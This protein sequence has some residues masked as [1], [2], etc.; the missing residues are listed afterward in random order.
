MDPTRESTY[1]F[2]NRFVG[3]MSKI[4]PD[5]YFHIGGDEVEG[6]I[7]TSNP[8]IA[9]FMKHKGFET[10]PQLQTYFNQR[11][12][13][14]VEKHRKKPIGWDEV[15]VPACP[16]TSWCSHGA[17][18]IHWPPAHARAIR[19]FSLPP[20]IS[21]RMKTNETHYL[22]DPIPADTTLTPEQQKLILGGEVCMWA[23]QLN[24]THHRLA[25]LAAHCGYGGTLLVA[26][27]RSRCGLDVPATSKG[28]DRAGAGG[29]E[30]HHGT[31][32]DAT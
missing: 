18:W 20:T 8:R 26:A 9:R 1:V 14:I 2:L 30:A 15:L 31:R 4:F 11:V 6:K 13:G 21:T 10:A 17:A 29:A 3:E 7:W 12:V 32:D 28:F 16:K 27:E 5:A 22:A 19:A 24:R 25:H 23:E